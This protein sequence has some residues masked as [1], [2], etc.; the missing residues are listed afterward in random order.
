MV[1]GVNNLNMYKWICGKTDIGDVV[2]D[3]KVGLN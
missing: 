3:E 1:C 2:K